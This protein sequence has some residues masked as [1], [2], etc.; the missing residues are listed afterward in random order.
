MSVVRRDSTSPVR[1]CG[2]EGRVQRQD[3][4]E[5]ALAQVGDDPLAGLGDVEIA[6]GGG[7]RRGTGR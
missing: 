6:D 5:Q 1:I 2:V 3:A 4:L 7:Q